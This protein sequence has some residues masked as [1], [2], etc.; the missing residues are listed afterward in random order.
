MSVSA[1]PPHLKVTDF[2]NAG[3][4]APD[5]QEAV[6]DG[7][8]LEELTRAMPGSGQGK[9]A[10]MSSCLGANLRDPVIRECRWR[11]TATGDHDV[12]AG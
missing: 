8:Q 3:L 11:H 9:T 6:L 12:A 5:I 4:L 1:K 10:P 2:C 7:R